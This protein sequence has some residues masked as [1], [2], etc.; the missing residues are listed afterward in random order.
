MSLPDDLKFDPSTFSGT[1]RLFPLPNLVM[2]PHVLQ[3]LHVFEPRY[4]DMLEDA[5]AGD[6]LIAMAILSPGWEKDYEGQPPVE[7]IACLGR[8]ATHA[9]LPD[10]RY[11]LL[12]AG[13]ARVVLGSELSPLVSFRRAKAAIRADRYPAKLAEQKAELQ[14][15]L[16]TA[17]RR[18]LPDTH[19]V[20][21]PLTQLLAK[22]IDLAVLTDIVAYTLDLPLARKSKLLAEADVYKRARWL[23]EHLR[24][25]GKD[26]GD[27][28]HFPPDFSV[29]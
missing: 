22:E 13:V 3:P 6:R 20:Q 27:E 9:Q 7:K 2:F 4:R 25:R 19:Q 10:G 29:N 15:H 8:V 12:L 26:A 16:F 1:V 18:V 14:E 11:N 28:T 23:V 5:L 24:K 21:A 17:F